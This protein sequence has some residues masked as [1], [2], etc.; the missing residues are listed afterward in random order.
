MTIHSHSTTAMGQLVKG[1]QSDPDFMAYVLAR[2]QHQEKI[3][4]QDLPAVLGT[5]PGLVSRLAVC[6]RP[7][8]SAPNFATRVRE[9]ADY[10]LVD[11]ALLASIIR[12]VSS[13]D[14]LS[15]FEQHQLLAARD[16]DEVGPEDEPSP[17]PKKVEG[18]E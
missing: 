15:K 8:T 9:I 14:A 11:E 1:L 12:Q 13:I 16:R 10:T 2:Y 5:L 4:D 7:D 3:S 18:K 6:R 17:P